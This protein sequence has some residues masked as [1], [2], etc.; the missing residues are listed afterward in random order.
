MTPD[1]DRL[2]ASSDA[3]FR[4]GVTFAFGDPTAKLYGLARLSHGGDAP[5]GLAVLYAGGK[6]VAAR[7]G[8][9]SAPRVDEPCWED[10]GAAGLR[11][12][13]VR[14]LEAWTVTWDDEDGAFDLR[15]EACSAPAALDAEDPVAKAGGMEGYEQLCHVTGSVSHGGRT[16]QVRCLG[17]RGQL[18]GKPDWGRIELARTLSAWMGED[19]ALTLA[20]VRPAKAKGHLDEAVSGFMF[21]AGEAVQIADPRLSTTYDGEQRQR[22]AGLE[23]WMTEE[24][25]HARRVA[26]EVVCGTTLDLGEQRLDSAF[27]SW[28]MEGREGVGRYD[29]LRRTASSGGGR[30]RLR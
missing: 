10:V 30:K 27:F 13:V 16:Y 25:D 2:H 22:R 19:R 24:G 18:W 1:D 5:N 9:G 21:E 6:P 11:V 20:C 8:G 26:G 23:L 4:D 28:R 15:F 12:S 29:V 3:A 7:A 17:Q 14:P